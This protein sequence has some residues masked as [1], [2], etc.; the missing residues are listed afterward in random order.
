VRPG[1]W[2]YERLNDV[3]HVDIVALPQLNQIGRQRRFYT[4]LYN[5]LATL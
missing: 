4:A 1:K 5:R 3:D 2:Y